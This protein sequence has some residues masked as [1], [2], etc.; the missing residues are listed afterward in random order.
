MPPRT[1]FPMP[2]RPDSMRPTAG[3]ASAPPR[4]RT[5]RCC[6][7]SSAPGFVQVPKKRCLHLLQVPP[8]TGDERPSLHVWAR[9]SSVAPMGLL[10][11]TGFICS[12]H[13]R[14]SHDLQNLRFWMQ[15]CTFTGLRVLTN[16]FDVCCGAWTLAAMHKQ[17]H[18]TG[19][20]NVLSGQTPRENSSH[21]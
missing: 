4:P 20:A 8:L 18:T 15:Y 10:A 19:T 2:R 13:L 5:T 21:C 3:R 16:I 17:L 9:W 6:S 14:P 12:P 7:R 11:S 1:R